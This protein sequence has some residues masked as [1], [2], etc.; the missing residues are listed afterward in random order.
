MNNFITYIFIC[1]FA[2]LPYIAGAAPG[3]VVPVREGAC[4]ETFVAQGE[5]EAC[6]SVNIHAPELQDTRLVTIKSVLEDGTRVKAGDVVVELEDADFRRALEAATNDAEV[7]EAEL[8]KARFEAKNEIIDLELGVRRKELELEKARAMVIEDAVVFSK[9]EREKARLGV[10][11]EE[12]ELKYAREALAE[13]RQKRDA[14]LRVKEL[15]LEQ[16]RRKIQVQ[17]ENIARSIIRA[18]AAGIVYKPFIRLNNEMGRIEANKVVRTG[19]KL[20]ELPSLD[21][22]RGVVY[23]PAVDYPSLRVGDPASLTLTVRPDL[24]CRAVISAK[25]P[26]PVSRNERLGR[27]DPEGF[28]KEYNVTL[29]IPETDPI[30]RPGLSFRAEIEATIATSCLFI[31]RAALDEVQADR[32]TVRVRSGGRTTSRPVT[33]GRRGIT[34]IEVTSGLR[35][36]EEVALDT[37]PISAEPEVEGEER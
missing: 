34:F 12:L 37:P 20:L 21:R 36:G 27:N 2:V 9:I 32:A 35:P 11:L 19:D 3:I 23:V 14:T 22:F 1:I 15:Q 26:Y 5:I 33:L 8:E 31:P 24:P 17:E 25:E 29:E 28:L 10:Q 16:A 4:R 7:A 18:P 13:F 30:F 6:E